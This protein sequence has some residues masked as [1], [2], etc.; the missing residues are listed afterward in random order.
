MFYFHSQTPFI[1]QLHLLL[2]MKKK[3]TTIK[4]NI[5]MKNN[6]K[7]FQIIIISHKSL[8]QFQSSLASNFK[9]CMYQM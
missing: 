3:T 2:T 5:I 6:Q 7:L 1:I 9:T 4:F 8:F